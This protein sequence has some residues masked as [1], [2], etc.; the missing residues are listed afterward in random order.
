MLKNIVNYI[1]KIHND[2][3]GNYEIIES[4][5]LTKYVGNVKIYTRDS[6]ERYNCNSWWRGEKE[7]EFICPG[8]II[9]RRVRI[10]GDTIYYTNLYNMEIVEQIVRRR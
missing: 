8:M 7:V 1:N 3:F 2:I 9:S 6:V 4:Y 5:T 10:V